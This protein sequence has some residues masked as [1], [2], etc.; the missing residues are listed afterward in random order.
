MPRGPS[1]KN[2]NTRQRRN[3]P[4]IPFTDLPPD[5]PAGDPP[6]CPYLLGEAGQEWWDWAWKQP[7][8]AA[9][10]RGAVYFVARRAA[11]EDDLDT[12]DHHDFY[13]EE[14]LG[15][16]DS[17][18]ARR[19]RAV[20]GRLKALATGRASVIKEMREL[21]NRLGLNP[22]AMIDLRWRVK[23]DAEVSDIEDAREGKARDR[24]GLRAV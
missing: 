10:D 4:T 6:D 5:G 14:F 22:K 16:E 3:A 11:L 23:P 21:E 12:L 2:P 17:E 15:L 1:P 7:Q 20:I 8:A 18:A 9:W 24:G 13:V 19:L